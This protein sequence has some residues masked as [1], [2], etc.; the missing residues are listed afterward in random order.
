[1]I[2][3]CNSIS[4]LGQSNSNS[5]VCVEC[6]NSHDWA[7]EHFLAG[8]CYTALDK[9]HN[10]EVDKYNSMMLEFLAAGL[11]PPFPSRF[12]QTTPR[13]YKYKSCTMAIV[14]LKDLPGGAVPGT[15]FP[16]SDLCTYIQLENAAKNVLEGCLSPVLGKSKGRA[17]GLGF[18]NPTGYDIA[19]TFIVPYLWFRLFAQLRCLIFTVAKG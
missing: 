12:A 17:G 4:C 6:I 16:T 15:S 13:K 2:F 7:T 14:M 1:M 3:S 18:V 5:E 19:G 9:F 10:R 11:N 8:D